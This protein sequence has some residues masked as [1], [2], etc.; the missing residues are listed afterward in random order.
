MAVRTADFFFAAGLALAA[1][2][3]AAGL[4]FAGVGASPASLV[5]IS[6]RTMRSERFEKR[7]QRALVVGRQ[8]RLLVEQP[9]A[10]V[11]PLVDDEVLALADAEQV[12]RQAFQDRRQIVLRRDLLLR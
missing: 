6:I 9:R 1:L 5:A 11:V 8:L 7:D 2:A 3:F 12:V 4:R 10:E